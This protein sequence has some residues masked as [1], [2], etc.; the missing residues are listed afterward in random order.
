MLEFVE[1]LARRAGET[2]LS[3]FRPLGRAE[4]V[5]RKGQMRNLVTAADRASE[6]LIVAALRE[7]FPEHGINGEEGGGIPGDGRH[8]WT[9]D[10]LDGTVNFTHGHPFFAVSIGLVVDGEP[11]LGVVHAPVLGETFVGEVGAGATLNGVPIGVSGTEDLMEAMLATGFAYVRNEHPDHNVDN[12]SRLIFK[13]RSIR[14][15]GAAAIDLAYVAAGRLDGFWEL[16]LAPWDVAAGAAIL[17]AAGGRITDFG[18]GDAYLTCG[19]VVASNGPLHEA[20]RGS[21]VP[22]R[23]L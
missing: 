8:V 13:A 16:H 12:F 4:I 10:P 3:H 7:E 21:L 6:D 1:R 19:H 9:V 18:G 2:L 20:I 23:A 22:L 14:R 5:D 17:L 15:A 11:L